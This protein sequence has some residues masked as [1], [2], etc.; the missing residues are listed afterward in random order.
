MQMF[1]WMAIILTLLFDPPFFTARGKPALCPLLSILDPCDHRISRDV[2]LA[3]AGEAPD[4]A[5][6]SFCT[7]DFH[8]APLGEGKFRLFITVDSKSRRSDLLADFDALGGLERKGAGE[9]GGSI[10][11]DEA[12][13]VAAQRW[14]QERI[15]EYGLQWR[16]ISTSRVSRYSVFLGHVERASACGAAAGDRIFLA[17]DAAHSH[18][19]H[20]GQ[21]ANAGVQDG[22]ALGWRLAAASAGLGEG[23]VTVGVLASY[24]MERLPAWR[25]LCKFADA[26][27]RLAGTPHPGLADRAIQLL[28]AALPVSMQ[29]RLRQRHRAAVCS[30]T[31]TVD[32]SST[33]ELAVHRETWC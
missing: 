4:V 29:A 23:G 9:V 10:A 25:A 11:P 14:M 1:C 17:G 20:G 8:I 22:Y 27:K 6:E 21:G 26:L 16:I 2:C 31:H 3:P 18:S 32:P 5:A 12:E 30:W 19:P 15:A 13:L 33:C 7:R 28:W 24:E